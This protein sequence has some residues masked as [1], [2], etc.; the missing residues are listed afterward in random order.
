M[1]VHVSG[2]FDLCFGSFE[3]YYKSHVTN[4]IRTELEVFFFINSKKLSLVP[5]NFVSLSFFF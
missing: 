1:Y 4:Q 3:F 5:I 2:D